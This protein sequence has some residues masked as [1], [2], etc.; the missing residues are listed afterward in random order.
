MRNNNLHQVIISTTDAK[1]LAVLDVET[2]PQDNW[3]EHCAVV[4]GKWMLDNPGH[5][6]LSSHVSNG[7]LHTWVT[8][9]H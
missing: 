4:F 3:V 6:T 5:K 2:K 9:L 8:T 7:N 1:R